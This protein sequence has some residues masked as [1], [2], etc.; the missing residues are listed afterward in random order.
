MELVGGSGVGLAG[1][2]VDGGVARAPGVGGF[3]GV[4]CEANGPLV[5]RG[6]AWM[7][8]LFWHLGSRAWSSS[9]VYRWQAGEPGFLQ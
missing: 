7:Q 4:T 3:F 9:E 1:R 8:L 2:F 6:E 5:V